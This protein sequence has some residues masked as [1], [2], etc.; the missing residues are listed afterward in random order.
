[1]ADLGVHKTDLLIFLLETKVKKVTAVLKTLDKKDAEGNL[2]NV[3]DNAICIYEMENGAVGTMTASWTYYGEEDNSTIIYG[4]EGIL[5]I[6][7]VPN[8]SIVRIGK[9]GTKIYYELD[10][11]Q[12]N[13]NQ[14]KS[15]IIDSWVA[16]IKNDTVP[17]VNGKDA[18]DAMKAIFAALES[19]E[20]GQTVEITE[21]D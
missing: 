6:Y 3:D 18:L 14:T 4:S 9:D 13:D 8:Y 5:K 12:T 20:S 2:I 17:E 10:K 16:A 1:M 21:E 19:S 11:M 15:G 7:D